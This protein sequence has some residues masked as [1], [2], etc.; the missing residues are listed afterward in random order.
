[1]Q[2][3]PGLNAM[4]TIVTLITAAAV[5][6]HFSLGCCAHHAHAAEG[7][8]CHAKA[9]VAVQCHK[10]HDHGRGHDASEPNDTPPAD[11]DSS[12]PDQHCND[13]QCVFLA[14]GKT[15]IAKE[16]FVAVL[17]QCIEPGSLRSELL[18]EVAAIDSGGLIA[19][20][21]RTHLFNQVL[22]I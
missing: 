6:L 19:L 8:I 4:R 14:A 5:A 7:T 21:V 10:C 13:S 2:K 11:S 17:P 3:S 16:V 22:L 15:V 20:P 18:L 12:C 1:M 9:K